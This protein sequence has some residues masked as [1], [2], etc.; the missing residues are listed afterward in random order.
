MKLYPGF[1]YRREE[2]NLE[3]GTAGQKMMSIR[4]RSLIA[5]L[6][7]IAGLSI[8][9][10]HAQ[11]GPTKKDHP[12]DVPEKDHFQRMIE[13]VVEANPTLQSQRNLVKEIETLPEPVR[14][15]DLTLGL[16]TG[17]AVESADG[18]E[19]RVMPTGSIELTIPLYSS[20]TRRKIALDRLTTQKDLAKAWQDYH[21]FKNSIISDLLTR[22]DKIVS[23]KNELEGQKKLLSLL[24][25]NLEAL[26]KQVN[27]GVA[28]PSDLWAISERIMATETKIS[29][30]L[31][32]LNTLKRETA[33]N[34]AGTK[35]PELLRM[36]G[37]ITNQ[38]M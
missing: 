32:K 6:V 13:L 16:K 7:L 8:G 25:H 28:R 20:A 35:W 36:L 14:G 4:N 11:S 19:R 33:V 15:L 34:L 31:S 2:K 26:K 21:R 30:L 18:W 29:N 22:L 17:A 3:D 9:W 5:L 1:P 10:G 38:D 24:Q 23:L 12:G 27:A 37:E